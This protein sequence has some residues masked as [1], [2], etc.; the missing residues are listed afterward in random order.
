MKVKVIFPVLFWIP[1]KIYSAEKKKKKPC[2]S[3]FIKI[4]Y[5]KS[6]LHPFFPMLR[7]HFWR[8]QYRRKSMISK[9][10]YNIYIQHVSNV[11]TFLWLVCIWTLWE[12]KEQG[13]WSFG[14]LC[15]CMESVGLHKGKMTELKDLSYSWV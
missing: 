6:C 11:S 3:Q 10:I 9:S 13:H 1:S 12:S 4:R 8:E 5:R 14:K 15:S 2:N 7:V